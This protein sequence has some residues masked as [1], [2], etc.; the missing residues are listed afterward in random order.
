MDRPDVDATLIDELLAMTPEERIA[1]NDRTLAMI[2][3]LRDGF[4]KAAE[5]SQQTRSK[6][7]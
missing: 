3:E 4:A 7:R 6:S 5:S 1:Q 2:Q